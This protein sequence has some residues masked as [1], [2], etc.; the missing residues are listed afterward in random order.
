MRLFTSLALSLLFLLAPEPAHA[1]VKVLC[2]IGDSQVAGGSILSGGQGWPS[3]LQTSR[4]GQLFGSING[5]VGGSTAAAA[6]AL[7][8][9]NYQGRGCTHAVVLVGTNDLAS[10]T[11]ATAVQSTLNS[12]VTEMQAD[13]SGA[14]SGINVTVLTVPP[15]GGSANWDATKETQR[16]A[17]RTSILAMAADAVVDLEDMAGTGDPVEMAAAYR[18][19]DLLHFNGTATT[20]GTQKVADLIDAVVTW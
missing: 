15:R 9:S 7:Y 18:Y 3:L 1:R 10:S 4:D 20:G 2:A 6:K 19:S 5:G 16:L 12:L 14:P 13:T 17:L 8:E 11:A